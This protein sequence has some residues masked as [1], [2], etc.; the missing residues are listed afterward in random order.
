MGRIFE[1]RK[2][3]MFKRWSRTSKAFTKVGKELAIA[4]RLGGADPQGN[5]RLRMAIQTA[6][7]LN[8]PKDRI[9]NAINRAASRDIAS[10]DEVTYEGYGPHG[11][12]LFVETA[13]DNPT[14][15]VANVR[16][17]I[18]KHGGSLATN[19]ALDYLFVRQGNFLITP[20]AGDLEEFE[21]EMIDYGLEEMFETEE[22][23]ALQCSFQNFGTLQKALEERKIEVKSAGSERVPLNLTDL[24]AEQ[25]AAIV[26]LIE[27][28][29]EDDDVQHVYHTLRL[30]TER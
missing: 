1:K 6:R 30:S 13:T 18:T 14:R 4:V 7:S 21:L 28:L 16:S 17:I 25:E 22:G 10:M 15:T 8:M 5:P 2:A 20:P 9:E 23:L 24:P 11:V 26:E 27:A 19:G 29:E 12:A 3:R